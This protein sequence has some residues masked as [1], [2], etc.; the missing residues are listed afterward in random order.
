M[1]YFITGT[2]TDCGKTLIT[3]GLMLLARR[4]EITV[5]G[6]K[7]VASGGITTTHGRHNSDALAIQKSCTKEPPYHLVNPYC[8]EPAIAPHIAAEQE[9]ITIE[10]GVIEVAREQLDAKSEMMFVEGV[11]GWRVPLGRDLDVAGLCKFLDTPAILVAGIRLGCINH[12]LLTVESI[13]ASQVPL[14]GW[15]AN[16]IEP[17]MQVREENIATLESLVDAPLLGIVPWLENATAED[18]AGYLDTSAIW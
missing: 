3:Q 16:C 13:R 8:F 4:Q 12:T 2:D 10:P 18:V 9:G 14:A 15:V 1:D 11:G 6:M 17:D 7:P 5:S